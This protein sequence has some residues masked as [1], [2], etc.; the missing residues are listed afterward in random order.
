MTDSQNSNPFGFDFEE[1][2]INILLIDLK[3]INSLCQ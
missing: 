2:F 1:V 3:L